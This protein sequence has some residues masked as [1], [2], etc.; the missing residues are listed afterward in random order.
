VRPPTTDGE[1]YQ[2]DLAYIQHHGFSAF[3]TGASPGLLAILRGEG[4]TSGHV[5]DLGC[6]D[7]TW[8]RALTEA[9]FVASGIDQSASL[10]RY[11]RSVA[12]TATVKRRSVY[13]CAFPRCHAITALGEVLSYLPPRTT[14]VQSL[15]RLFRRAYAALQPGGLLVFDLFVS[16]SPLS[17]RTWRTGRGW[18]VLVHIEER[19]DR[20]FRHIITF[21]SVD[22]RYRRGSEEHVLSVH[23]RASVLSELRR[24]G[25]VARTSRRYGRFELPVRRLAFIARK[26]A[27][28]LLGVHVR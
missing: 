27:R 17:Y 16:G 2:D 28:K 21:R 7:G 6:G 18:A 23:T 22:G 11:A 26:P 10:V 19:G 4:I 5:L 9:G 14:R 1:I 8:L 3:A 25:F 15:R 12:P 20:L 24:A 13:R